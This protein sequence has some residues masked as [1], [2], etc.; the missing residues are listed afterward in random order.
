MKEQNYYKANDISAEL[1]YTFS[2]AYLTR[3]K[4]FQN[5]IY[6]VRTVGH[7]RTKLPKIDE[8]EII[9]FS[10]F[11]ND[12]IKK[13]PGKNFKHKNLFFYSLLKKKFER[14]NNKITY[15]FRQTINMLSNFKNGKI[16]QRFIEHLR[17]SKLDINNF[18]TGSL[19]KKNKFKN[20]NE[21]KNFIK[22]LEKKNY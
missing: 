16:F 9:K 1:F 2:I 4:Q 13:E 17:I 19:S 6:L 14:E 21:L 18:S 10:I 20:Y 11:L 5:L 3:I 8:K 22:F 12:M 7:K 15:P